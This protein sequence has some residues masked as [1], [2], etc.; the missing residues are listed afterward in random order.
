MK[1]I[2][3]PLSVISCSFWMICAS[4]AWAQTWS[5]EAAVISPEET[6]NLSATGDVLDIAVQGRNGEAMRGFVMVIAAGGRGSPC[7]AATVVNV[8]RDRFPEA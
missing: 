1:A 8:R 5:A 6:R 4:N 7:E 2:S 3:G